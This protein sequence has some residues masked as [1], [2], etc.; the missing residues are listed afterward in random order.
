M[1]QTIDASTEQN[2][3]DNYSKFGS[4]VKKSSIVETTPIIWDLNISSDDDNDSSKQIATPRKSVFERLSKKRCH[5]DTKNASNNCVLEA[6]SFKNNNTNIEPKYEV[7]RNKEQKNKFAT[8]NQIE[9]EVDEFFKN[10]NNNVIITKKEIEN[11]N[12]N[13]PSHIRCK[14]YFALFSKLNKLNYLSHKYVPQGYCRYGIKCT[15]V[16]CCYLHSKD[17]PAS[18]CLYEE[19]LNKQCTNY[20]CKFVHTTDPEYDTVCKYMHDETKYCAYWNVN[21]SKKSNDINNTNK[22]DHSQNDY[23]IHKKNQKRATLNI[24]C[25]NKNITKLCEIF[26]KYDRLESYKNNIAIVRCNVNRISLFVENEKFEVDSILI[27]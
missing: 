5:E 4:I 15:Y 11:T 12:I 3:S 18:V 17:V 2:I 6:S 23:K 26:C 9:K 14:F 20:E 16:N 7:K 8:N 10:R 22:I 21:I 25:S 1:E 19:I 24:A 27:D 13:I